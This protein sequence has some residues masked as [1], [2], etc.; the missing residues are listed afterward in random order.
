MEIAWAIEVLA[1]LDRRVQLGSE[2]RMA[3]EV[4]VD[5]RL[6]NPVQ[7]ELIDPMAPAQRFSQIQT[8]VEIDHQ[9]HIFANRLAHG[10]YRRH[11]VAKLVA[12]EPKLQA[13]K[14]SFVA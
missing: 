10:G 11:I 5:D 6:F 12:S 9:V 1:D 8:L 13:S 14:P 7:A 2:L 4:G 3:V